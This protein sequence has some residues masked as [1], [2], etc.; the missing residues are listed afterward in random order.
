MPTQKEYNILNN[1]KSTR[2]IVYTIEK[3]FVNITLIK[4]LG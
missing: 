1:L 3:Y 4:N 2:S